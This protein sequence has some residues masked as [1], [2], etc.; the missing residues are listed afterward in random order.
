MPPT[1]GLPPTMPPSANEVSQVV[2]ASIT[3]QIVAWLCLVGAYFYGFRPT[4]DATGTIT[5]HQGTPFVLKALII[6][7]GLSSMVELVLG[8]AM[9]TRMRLFAITI[10]A[11]SLVWFAIVSLA[12]FGTRL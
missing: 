8:L 4:Q 9:W 2:P 1:G 12:W 11:L 5:L 6:V 7:G 10:M 3:L